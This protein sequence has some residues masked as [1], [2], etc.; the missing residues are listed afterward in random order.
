MSTRNV[1]VAVIGG[2][3][4]GCA[5]A[6]A[7]A[8]EGLRV[9]VLERD[10]VAAHASGGA[11]GIVSSRDDPVGTPFDRLNRASLELHPVVAEQLR[12]E[13][14]IDVEYQRDGV[15]TLLHPH[16]MDAEIRF[17][18]RLLDRAEM[19]EL[20]PNIGPAWAG[21]I[22]HLN[23]GQVNTARFTQALAE[24]AA[25]R[26]AVIREGVTV[27][28]LVTEGNR[29]RGVRTTEGEI[30][31]EWVVLAA[32]PWSGLLG[33]RIGVPLPVFPVKGEIVWAK[34]RPRLLHRPVFAGCYL[35]PK[36]EQGIAIGA[37]HIRTGFDEMPTVG[38][39]L[40]LLEVGVEAVPALGAAELS[41][42]WS[43]VR[44]GTP[45]G[46]PILGPAECLPGLIL[47][48]GHYAYGIALSLITAQVVRSFVL[49]TPPPVD[50]AAF[51]PERFAGE[52]TSV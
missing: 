44:P 33:E 4:I 8:G 19:L 15:L 16:E 41:R 11:A 26:G 5:A 9:V 7:L 30:G 17:D 14:G 37:T 47:A 42:V 35:V 43:S 2:G 3:V 48:T 1:D 40:D 24:G 31:A 32:G 18:A 21:A 51:R 22:Y 20:E 25:R 46:L 52:V 28:D 39:A 6:Y 13:T 45:D 12:A 49:G 36:P 50:V 38:G 34:S 23:D 29:V 10:R 27:R